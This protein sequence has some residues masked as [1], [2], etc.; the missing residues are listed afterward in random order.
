MIN[1]IVFKKIIS[2]K[3]EESEIF[4]QTD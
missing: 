2:I 1:T 4:K 3:N